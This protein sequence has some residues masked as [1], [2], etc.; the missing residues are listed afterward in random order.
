MSP[1]E[2]VFRAI[3][4]IKIKLGRNSHTTD[5]DTHTVSHTFPT[6]IKHSPAHAGSA[7]PNHNFLSVQ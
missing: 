6:A 2:T 3:T 7:S 1:K 5:M 4:L